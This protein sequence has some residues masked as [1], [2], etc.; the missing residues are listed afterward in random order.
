[1][2]VRNRPVLD[3]RHRPRWQDELRSQQIVVA[4]FAAAIALALGIFGATVWSNYYD[5]HLRQVAVVQG[6]S[7]DRDAL[8]QRTGAMATE[9]SAK[10]QELQSQLGGARDPVINQ[11]MNVINGQLQTLTGDATTSLVDGAFMRDEAPKLGISVSDQEVNAEIARR[12]SL[13]LRIKLLGISIN[14]LPADAKAGASPTGAQWAAAKK[15]AD[16]VLAQ[17]KGGADFGKLA[18]EKSGDA[19]T[20]QNGGVIGWVSEGDA[21]YGK[22]FDAAK[23]AKVGDL[24][25]PIKDS[26]GYTVLKVDDRR[27]AGTDPLYAKLL[28]SGTSQEAYRSYVRDDLLRQKFQ[29][30]FG[31]NVIKT[32]QPQRKVAEIFISPDQQGVPVPKLHLRHI[33]IQPLPGKDDQSKATDAQ[34][35]AALEKAK[36]IH[37]EAVKPDANW[38]ELAKQSDDTGTKGRAGDLGWYD[39]A[40]SPFVQTFK[41]AVKKLRVGEVSEPVKT[42]FGYHIIKV[43]GSRVNAA[44]EAQQLVAKLKKDPNSFAQLARDWSEDTASAPKGGEVGWVAHYEVPA[45]RDAAIFKLTREN[46]ISDP[47]VTSTG[48]Y[49]Y[50][51]LDSSDSM[52][53]SASR[54]EQIKQSGF[55]PWFTELKQKAQVWVDPDF[56]AA[57]GTGTSGISG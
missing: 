38:Y 10:G 36:K 14:A 40:S 19:A 2:S 21:A 48:T 33:L 39:P 8:D 28:D 37:A 22:F 18:S 24:I 47:I 26:T 5:A 54:L 6:A 53:V 3:R 9:L 57:S 12:Q 30:Y 34:W 44:D 55:D 42:E 46:P 17:L 56:Q 29:D 16:D 11:Q 20:K 50:K 13:P 41:D 7:F 23:G 35:A 15:S 43:I 51:L 45:A 25:G 27:E 4:A 32:K 1:M 49:I 52:E 31:S